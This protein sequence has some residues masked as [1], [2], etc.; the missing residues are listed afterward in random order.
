MQQGT[1]PAS[2]V[3]W[4]TALALLRQRILCTLSRWDPGRRGVFASHRASARLFAQAP[5]QTPQAKSDGEPPFVWRACTHVQ[6]H[7]DGG[8]VGEQYV[9]STS[10]PSTQPSLLLPQSAVRSCVPNN[11]QHIPHTSHPN[12]SRSSER[13]CHRHPSAH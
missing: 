5:R 6:V 11:H 10:C 7:M 8:T 13:N 9:T 4:V 2:L 1:P 3:P 12:F